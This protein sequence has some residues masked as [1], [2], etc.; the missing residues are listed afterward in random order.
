MW[1]FSPDSCLRGKQATVIDLFLSDQEA[2]FFLR[3]SGSQLPRGKLELPPFLMHHHTGVESCC[4][5]SEF[6]FQYLNEVH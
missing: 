4:W 6:H 1:M 5:L 2:G 3:Q